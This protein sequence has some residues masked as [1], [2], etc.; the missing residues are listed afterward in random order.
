[1]G[2]SAQNHSAAQTPSTRAGGSASA[3]MAE[4][5]AR[6]KLCSEVHDGVCEIPMYTLPGM[7]SRIHGLSGFGR[8]LARPTFAPMH[9][10]WNSPAGAGGSL[11]IQ[12]LMKPMYQLASGPPSAKRE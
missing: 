7:T 11:T 4:G 9:A 6:K 1:M 2:T 3:G 10:R 5:A 12:A 8:V